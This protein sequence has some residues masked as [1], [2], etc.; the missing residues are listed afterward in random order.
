[1]RGSL[2]PRPPAGRERLVGVVTYERQFVHCIQ[3]KTDWIEAP[4]LLR[5]GR[6]GKKENRGR[7]DQTTA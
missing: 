4:T 5:K 6:S 7:P 2:R 1:V 3:R